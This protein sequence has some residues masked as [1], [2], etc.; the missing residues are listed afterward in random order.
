[1]TVVKKKIYRD[2]NG[3]VITEEEHVDPLTGKTTITK[4]IKDA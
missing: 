4:T 3:N 1:V 2:K